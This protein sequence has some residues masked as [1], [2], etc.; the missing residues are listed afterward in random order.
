MI[1]RYRQQ[2]G[3]HRGLCKTAN[4]VLALL[5]VG[6][7]LLAIAIEHSTLMLIDT[8]LSPAGWLPQGAV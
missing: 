6:A 2:A 1:H 5:N 8:P 4:W 3:S 7:S